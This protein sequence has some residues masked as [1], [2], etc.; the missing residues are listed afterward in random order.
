MDFGA[1]FMQQGTGRGEVYHTPQSLPQSS[2]PLRGKNTAYCSERRKV[3][4]GFRM[5]S[6]EFIIDKFAHSKL[7]IV[8]TEANVIGLVADF[9][10]N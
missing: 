2:T 8:L 9:S 4:S 1:F 7:A 5:L 10:F 3:A 6:R